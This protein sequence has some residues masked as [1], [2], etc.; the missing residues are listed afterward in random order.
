MLG[1]SIRR[2]RGEAGTPRERPAPPDPRQHEGEGPQRWGRLAAAALLTAG[3]L[4]GAG[5][6]FASRVLY[7][8]IEASG[9]SSPVPDLTGAADG[10]ARGLIQAA[11]LTV[12]DVSRLPHPDQPPGTVL[13]QAP[14]AGQGARPWARVDYAVS[15]GAPQVRVPDLVGFPAGTAADVLERA[16]M[17]VKVRE[18][19]DPAPQGR[20]LEV[21]P[22]PGTGGALPLTVTLTVSAGPPAGTLELP[23]S[24]PARVPPAI[25]PPLR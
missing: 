17:G 19:S 3:L 24:L 21:A 18:V 10:E 16:G 20:V 14:L 2:R 4:F 9:V 22:P 23:D 15:A 6:L 5:Y 8:P 25:I 7:P 12:G 11:G 13:A 1:D